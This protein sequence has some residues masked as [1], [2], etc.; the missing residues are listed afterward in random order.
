M[1][2]V[3]Q[4]IVGIPS[5]FSGTDEQLDECDINLLVLKPQSA[6]R[7]LPHSIIRLYGQLWHADHKPPAARYSEASPPR[8]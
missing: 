3:I 5:A 4:R 6:L 1:E 8:S 7:S 2:V